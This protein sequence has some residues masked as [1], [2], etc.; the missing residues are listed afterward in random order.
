MGRKLQSFFSKEKTIRY[1]FSK[2]DVEIGLTYR[3]DDDQFATK[4]IDIKYSGKSLYNINKFEMFK[5][6][7]SPEPIRAIAYYGFNLESQVPQDYNNIPP[8]DNST[9]I[10]LRNKMGGLFAALTTD[11]VDLK[12]NQ[13]GHY[14][15]P[16]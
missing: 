11:F 4:K 13:E 15:S 5:G 3:L 9:A 1:V 14:D 7:V 6:S 2:D 8:S 12:A 10:F 16:G